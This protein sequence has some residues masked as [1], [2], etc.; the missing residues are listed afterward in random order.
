MTVVLTH[1]QWLVWCLWASGATRAQIAYS[2]G[3]GEHSVRTI[4]SRISARLGV[5][6]WVEASKCD[7]DHEPYRAPKVA[8]V[9]AVA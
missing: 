1:R 7:V 2:L 8:P 4:V 3:I 6:G 9:G 5:R